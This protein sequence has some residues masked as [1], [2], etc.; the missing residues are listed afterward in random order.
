MAEDDIAGWNSGGAGL[1]QG[2]LHEGVTVAP[3]A[4]GTG[5]PGGEESPVRRL[6]G[7]LADAAWAATEAMLEAHK[8][9][10]ADE[11]ASV[12]DAVR[13]TGQSIDQ[14]ESRIIAQY[15]ERAA[16]RVAATAG[17]MRE[18]RWGELAADLE[19][20]ARRRPAWFVLGALAGGFALS[21]LLMA[22]AER[23]R[24]QGY[25]AS[26]GTGREPEI[27]RVEEVF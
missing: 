11:V 21:R 16:T 25:R 6:I 18:R 19:A 23:E 17:A 27:A 12:A 8:R 20:F 10:A 13:R 26:G 9:L 7:E 24:R 5:R 3:V 14:T 22:A 4:A 1:R 2:E 15:S